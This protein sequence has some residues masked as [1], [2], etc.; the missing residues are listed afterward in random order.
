MIS[1]PTSETHP[2]ASPYFILEKN[3]ACRSAGEVSFL[4]QRCIVGIETA[5]ADISWPE[6]PDALDNE[7]LAVC[8]LK[9]TVEPACHQIVGS[10]HAGRLGVSGIRKLSDRQVMAKTPKV[11]RSQSHTRRHIQPGTVFEALQKVASG[12][13]DIDIAEARAGGWEGLF[14]RS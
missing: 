3:P 9:Q 5:G 8:T 4:C 12:V 14:R 2:T 13:E 11:E 1:I 10:N 6:R 7:R